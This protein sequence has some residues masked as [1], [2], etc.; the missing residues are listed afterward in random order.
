MDKLKHFLNRNKKPIAQEEFEMKEM[1]ESANKDDRASRVDIA[2]TSIASTSYIKQPSESSSFFAKIKNI[3]FGKNKSLSDFKASRTSV[4]N[5]VTDPAIKLA[6]KEHQRMAKEFLQ[7]QGYSGS[8]L[9]KIMTNLKSIPDEYY[10]DAV[11]DI[12]QKKF[13]ALGYVSQHVAIND[14]DEALAVLV[15]AGFSTKDA[16]FAILHAKENADKNNFRE[17]FKEIIESRVTSAIDSHD[18]SHEAKADKELMLSWAINQLRDK[19]IVLDNQLVEAENMLED[20]YLNVL[21]EHPKKSSLFINSLFMEKVSEI[22]QQP[23]PR[24]EEETEV[25]R[26]F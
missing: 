18:H 1:G 23:P 2:N 21:R 19:N 8:E 25:K 9:R 3:L 10:L 6:T 17:S 13:Q 22:I 7:K 12:P 11:E 5:R 26:L 20:I 15:S 16:E 4:K 14:F 24:D